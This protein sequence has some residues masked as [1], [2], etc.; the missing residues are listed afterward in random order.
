[1]TEGVIVL[2]R[3]PQADGSR[4]LRPTLLLRSFRPFGDFLA[5]GISTRLRLAVPGFDEVVAR[6]DLDFGRSGLASESVIRL[7]FLALI[8]RDRIVGVVGQ[9]SAERHARL[10]RALGAYLVSNLPTDFP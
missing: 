7:G 2:A 9:V 10:L 5:C 3:L 6:S 8:P 1:M 4:K